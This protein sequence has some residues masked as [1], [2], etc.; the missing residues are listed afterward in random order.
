M[1]TSPIINLKTLKLLLYVH[2]SNNKPEDLKVTVV[3]RFIIGD[4]NIQQ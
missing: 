3:V 4:V 1:F 2:I